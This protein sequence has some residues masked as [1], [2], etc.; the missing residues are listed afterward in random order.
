MKTSRRMYS[1][2]KMSIRPIIV[3]HFKESLPVFTIL[4]LSSVTSRFLRHDYARVVGTTLARRCPWKWSLVQIQ[5]LPFT[6]SFS[7]SVSLSSDHE[8]S[9][10]LSVEKGTWSI[11]EGSWRSVH[12]ESD[13]GPKLPQRAV[14]YMLTTD[15][16]NCAS[17]TPDH[18]PGCFWVFRVATDTPEA[19]YQ[20]GSRHFW[21]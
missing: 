12:H 15:E 18:T 9:G 14:W 1:L 2:P 5:P 21:A 16:S 20:T 3:A 6:V 17:D 19:S 13:D 4:L 7:L 10:K 8:E 11:P